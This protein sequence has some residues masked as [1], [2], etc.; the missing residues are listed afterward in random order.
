LAAAAYDGHAETVECL[1]ERGADVNATNEVSGLLSGISDAGE[2]RTTVKR[3]CVLRM[4]TYATKMGW[5]ALI[6]AAGTGHVSTID[7]LLAHGADV[8]ACAPVSL[9]YLAGKLVQRV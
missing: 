7:C 8:N 9:P 2:K 5:T 4:L 3:L 1:L 6:T